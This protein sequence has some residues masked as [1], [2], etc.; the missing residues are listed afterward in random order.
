MT[1]TVTRISALA[2]AVTVHAEDDLVITRTTLRPG[3]DVPW[4]WHSE[5]AD[6]FTVAE[7]E[8]EIQ[9]SAERSPIRLKTGEQ[10]SVAAG[11][12]HRVINAG[13]GNAVFILVQTGGAYDYKPL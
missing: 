3:G 5:V 9:F 13:D 4:H 11:L 1:P 10:A 7:G 8:I 6:G 12:P 2:E